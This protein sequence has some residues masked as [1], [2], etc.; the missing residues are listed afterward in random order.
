[1]YILNRISYANLWCNVIKF[2]VGVIKQI[3]VTPRWVKQDSLFMKV[4]EV[5][6]ERENPSVESEKQLKIFSN[7]TR[8]NFCFILQ[9]INEI[10]KRCHLGKSRTALC[11]I[12]LYS[13]D[14]PKAVSWF[15]P[16]FN[17]YSKCCSNNQLNLFS[18]KRKVDSATSSAECEMWLENNLWPL[19]LLFIS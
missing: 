6:I 9:E 15:S 4:E 19:L 11:I 7:R 3:L 18:L 2:R 12:I 13:P 1:M 8:Y 5:Q 17:A 10:K 14:N 16:Y